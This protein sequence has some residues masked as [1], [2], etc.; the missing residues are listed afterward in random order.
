MRV[1][2]GKTLVRGSHKIASYN[3]HNFYDFYVAH[4]LLF[5]SEKWQKA[6]DFIT[7]RK[8]L[9]TCVRNVNRNFPLSTFLL[10]RSLKCIVISF[11]VCSYYHAIITFDVVFIPAAFDA[12][13]KIINLQH[14]KADKMRDHYC[15]MASWVFL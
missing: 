10:S 12:W 2:R 11:P 14:C 7:L 8:I 5:Y 4:S 1:A 13:N 15:I 6:F 9:S 3:L